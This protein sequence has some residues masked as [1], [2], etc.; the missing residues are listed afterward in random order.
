MSEINLEDQV[1]SFLNEYGQILVNLTNIEKDE[2]LSNLCKEMGTEN[3]K[4]AAAC[5][6][7]MALC[8]NMKEDLTV[9][10]GPDVPEVC[11]T[12]VINRQEGA[13]IIRGVLQRLT[14]EDAITTAEAMLA[15]VVTL[16]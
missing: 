3:E 5:L 10:F 8:V 11:S 12:Q 16:H 2:N 13:N 4:Y 7:I 14:V 15:W 9:L 6:A 1:K